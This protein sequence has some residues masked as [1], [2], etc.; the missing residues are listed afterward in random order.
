[1]KRGLLLG[2]VA[3][4]VVMAIAVAFVVPNLFVQRKPAP[5]EIV[6]G[7]VLPMSGSFSQIGLY[8]KNGYEL[9]FSEVNKMG[10][11][12]VKEF[13]KRI[14]ISLLCMTT[15]LIRRR[16]PRSL[17]RLITVEKSN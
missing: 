4:V 1:V 6:V 3:A 15:N 16:A 9:Y 10:G 8:F 17:E 12:Y 11:V 7:A 2:I 13:D 14:P 5:Q